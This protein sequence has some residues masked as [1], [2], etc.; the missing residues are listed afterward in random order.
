MQ[1][2]ATGDGRATGQIRQVHASHVNARSAA[3]RSGRSQTPSV[4]GVDLVGGQA[5]QIQ[6]LVSRLKDVPASRDEVVEAVRSR[7]QQG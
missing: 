4:D 7:L 3:Q 1:I 5:D 2:P 6:T